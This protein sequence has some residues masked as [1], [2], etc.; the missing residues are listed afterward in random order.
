MQ[1]TRP[2]LPAPPHEADHRPLRVALCE[3]DTLLRAL[4]AEWLRRAGFEPVGRPPAQPVENVVLVVA[5]VAAPR[6]DGAA[7]ISVLRRSFPQARMLAIS[8]QFTPGLHGA[9]AAALELGADAVLAKPF[10]AGEFIA[11]V[12]ALIGS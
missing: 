2:T 1:Y 9:T 6:R 8:A 3:P 4:L 5:D 12:H 11:A 7:A 10:A